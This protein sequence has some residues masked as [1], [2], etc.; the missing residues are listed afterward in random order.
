M[1]ITRVRVFQLDVPIK[2]STIS[3]ERTMSCFD[4]TIVAIDT[5]KGLT[6][7]GESVPWGANFVAAFAKGVRAGLD[8]L[9]P[10]LIGCDPRMLGDINERMDGAMVGQGH[11]KS[12]LDM[13]CW[14]LLARS[15]DT[16]L[17]ML[18]G[19][20]LTPAPWV[21][22]SIPPL[23]DETLTEMVAALRAQGI[24]V[25]SGKSSGDVGRDIAYL[26]ALGEILLPG[27]AL[28]YD[29]N[30]GWQLDEALRIARGM[31]EIDVYFE[32]PCATYEECRAL[33]QATGVPL[34][35]DESALDLRDVLRAKADGVLDAL[36]LKTGRV[37]GLSKA[38]V[39]RD[40]CVALN[41]KMELQD[42]SYSE[43][44]CAASAHLAH[45]TPGRCIMSTQYPKGLAFSKLNGAPQVVDGRVR[46]PELPGLG[47]TPKLEV[48]GEPIAVYD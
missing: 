43:L 3:K 25:F 34:I 42:D 40:V 48:L 10:Q 5:D 18:L 30:G 8:E 27:E 35:L 14:D 31:G 29:G 19:G 45:A 33:R 12:A 26:R 22:G 21:I 47:A 23:V 6:G 9:A 20:M 46:A 1:R 11:V 39:I 41:V 16:P 37:G 44:S 17:Y 38:R 2:A 4:E 24:R 7:W 15:L 13:A 32:Q 36:N 28:K